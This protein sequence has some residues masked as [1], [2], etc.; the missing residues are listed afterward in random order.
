MG[1]QPDYVLDH[2]QTYE[3][4]ALM[5]FGYLRNKEDW[6]QTRFQSYVTAQCQSTKKLQATDI[7]K[8][9]WEEKEQQSKKEVEIDKKKI[10][11]IKMMAKEIIK[12]GLD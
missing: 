2:I 6:E 5:D 8:F 9:P 10:E 7:M 11:R 1:L 4:K 3:L 12:N